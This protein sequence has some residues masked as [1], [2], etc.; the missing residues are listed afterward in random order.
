MGLGIHPSPILRP[1]WY[2]QAER[3]NETTHMKISTFI[4]SILLCTASLSLADEPKAAAPVKIEQAEKKLAE[5]AQLLDVRTKE[6]WDEGHV[7]GAKLVTVTEEGFIDKAKALLDPKKPVV[8]YCR[9]G[10][11]SAMAT[12]QLRA[13][14]F[15]VYDLEGGITAWKEAGKPV[16]K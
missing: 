3:Q 4:T 15:T 16:E 8:V 7:K 12:E 1:L 13:A 11:R 2:S 14:G 10:K 9:S 6:E 5:G